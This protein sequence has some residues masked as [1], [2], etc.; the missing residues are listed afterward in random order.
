MQVIQ[1]K[2]KMAQTKSL[3]IHIHTI[4]DGLNLGRVTIFLSI[5]YF[6]ISDKDYLEM[7]KKIEILKFLFIRSI[8][9][10]P[11]FEVQKS[12]IWTLIQ[13]FLEGKKLSL[14]K[15]FPT[16]SCMFQSNDT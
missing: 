1:L 7:S 16:P 12:H 14:K 15:T 3:D 10:S 4:H 8:Y 9:E 5:I 13:K 2:P 6:I 11:N